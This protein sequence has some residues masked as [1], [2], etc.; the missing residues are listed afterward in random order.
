V[1]TRYYI[2]IIPQNWDPAGYA[3]QRRFL[4]RLEATDPRIRIVRGRIEP[5]YE[6]NPLADE[7]R[8]WL[9]TAPAG[10]DED[11][12]RTLRA[13][14]LA[15][16]QVKTPREKA[17][18]VSLAVDLIRLAAEGC[19]D[20]AYVLSADGDYTPAVETAVNAG[21]TVFAASPDGCFALS[22]VVRSYI[23]LKREW[24]ADCYRV[25]EAP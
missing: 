19:Y 20:A 12:A 2:G 18:D 9:D 17:V 23:R 1:E 16:T 11:A 15:K 5:R 8:A 4:A 3:A 21:K 24:F 6:P 14:A 25:R 7:I 10:V 13:M 22:R